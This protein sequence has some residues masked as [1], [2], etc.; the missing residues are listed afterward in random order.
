[1]NL[2]QEV[3]QREKREKNE[4]FSLFFIFFVRNTPSEGYYY[5]YG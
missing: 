4:L 5:I 2:T 1:M 3:C